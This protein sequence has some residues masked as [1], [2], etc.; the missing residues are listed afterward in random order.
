MPSPRRVAVRRGSPCALSVVVPVHDEDAVL[1]EF[2]RRLTGAIDGI[3]GG[4]EILYVDDGSSD[5][6]PLILRQ[7]RALDPRVGIVRLS[8]NFGK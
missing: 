4:A 8:R 3:A 2:H 6:T 1:L 5:S 7:L